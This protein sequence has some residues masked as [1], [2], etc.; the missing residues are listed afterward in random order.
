VGGGEA[1]GEGSEG[2]G[3]PKAG[4]Q[5]RAGERTLNAVCIYKPKCVRTM[6]CSLFPQVQSPLKKQTKSFGVGP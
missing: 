4:Q 1:R 5:E 3:G 2:S 6:P